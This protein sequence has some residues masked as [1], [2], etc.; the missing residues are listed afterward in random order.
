M[1][2]TRQTVVNDQI[3]SLDT[4]ASNGSVTGLVSMMSLRSFGNFAN[5]LNNVLLESNRNYT[6]PEAF[7][8]TYAL[9][10]S[11]HM[12]VPLVVHTV[13]APANV[14][15]RRVPA[16]ITKLPKVALWL[17][18]A[19]NT[20]FAILGSIIAVLA[21]R[22]TSPN[23]HQIQI[24]LSTAGIAAQLFNPQHSRRKAKDDK[25]LFEETSKNKLLRVTRRVGVQSTSAGGAEFFVHD[26]I[27]KPKSLD[28][29]DS[30]ALRH[31]HTL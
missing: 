30:L 11:K 20:A 14:V 15:Q 19:A 17:L 25:A 29:E 2:D 3:T 31:T 9:A 10:M 23:V 1:F 18:V 13:P 7:I 22:V 12:A 27:S 28:E 24:R 5:G 21:M 26:G 4:S 16:V 8:D 6:T